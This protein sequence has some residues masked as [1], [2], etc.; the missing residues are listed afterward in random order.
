MTP[1]LWSSMYNAL[2]TYINI[3]ILY[4]Y[5]YTYT[6]GTNKIHS[7]L[8]YNILAFIQNQYTERIDRFFIYLRVQKYVFVDTHNTNNNGYYCIVSIER[9]QCVMKIASFPKE[10]IL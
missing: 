1:S 3:C 4:M 10:S 8:L 5:M 7:Y 9:Y 6:S 2:Q